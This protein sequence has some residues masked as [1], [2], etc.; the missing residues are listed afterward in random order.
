LN[1]FVFTLCLTLPLFG[2]TLVGLPEYGV[3]LSG[4]PENPVV[5]NHSGKVV[6]GYDM[7]LADANGRGMILS[8][9][10]LATSV[11]PAGIPDGGAVYAHGNFPVNSTVPRPSPPQVRGT[12]LPGPIVT[13]TL[14]SV[15]FADGH[16][17][18]ADE[19][20]AFEQFAKKL[21]AVTEAGKLA[22]T[23]AWDQLDALAQAFR[24]MPRQPP[25]PEEDHTVY[26]FRQ[27]AAQRLVEAW[28]LK[29]DSAAAQL[30]EL[31]SSLPT[32]WK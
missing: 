15:I 11:Q 25:S 24:Q 12:G 16:F 6:I 18:G 2:Q 13:A 26:T 27:L 29:G 23:G 28:R 32:L 19:Q 5:E 1:R 3:T 20:N 9:Q 17:V 22:K 30:A 8:A 21:K 7:K 10:I 14:R 31:Y 4:S